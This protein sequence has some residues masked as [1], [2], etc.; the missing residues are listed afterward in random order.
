M[1]KKKMTVGLIAALMLCGLVG[2]AGDKTANQKAEGKQTSFTYWCP[3]TSELASKFQTLGEVAMY[4]EREK[5]SGVHIEFIHPPVGQESEQFNLMIASRELPDFIEY[6]YWPSYPGGPD[7]AVADGI[8]YK[9]NDIIDSSAP[10]FKA[11]LESNDEWR[12]Q[13]VTDEGTIYAFPALNTGTVSYTHLDV[14]KRQL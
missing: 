8:I 2:C 7:K 1:N 9:L 5:M 3:M 14:Y 11:A 13:T 4:Q 10:S 12:R 6:N